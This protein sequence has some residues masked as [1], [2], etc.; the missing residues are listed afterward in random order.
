MKLTS[1]PMRVRTMLFLMAVIGAAAV[2][3]GSQRA[4]AQAINLDKALQ[5]KVVQDRAL[6]YYHFALSKWYENEGDLSRALSEMQEAVRFNESEPGIY[7]GLANILVQ[8]RRVTD[9]IE[10]AQKAAKLD[11]KDPEPHWTL[12]TVYLRMAEGAQARQAGDSIRQA[13]RELELMKEAA[14]DDERAYF[15]IG[16]CYMNLDQPE[17][18]IAALERWQALVPDSDQGYLTIA[19]YFDQAGKQDKAIEYLRKAVEAQPDSVQAI[20]LLAQMYSKAKREKDAIPLYQKIVE[21]T[22][23]TPELKMKLAS[24]LLDEGQSDKALAMLRQ[25][26]QSDPQDPSI[27][28]LLSRALVAERQ[29]ADAIENLKSIVADDPGDIEAQFCLGNAYEQSGE[30]AEAVK[31]F[32]RLIE[33]S[34]SG[35]EELKKNLPL[36]QQHL[37]LSYQDMGDYQKAIAIYEEMAKADPSPR[38]YFALINAYRIDRQFD[39]ALSL[40]KQQYE[41]NPKEENLALVYA[42]A[43]ADAGKV[44]DGAE[45]LEKLLPGSPTN[46][47]VYINLSQIYVQAKRFNDAEKVLRRAEERQL[48]KDRVRFQLAAVYDKQKDHDKAESIFK[49][50]LKEN[51]NDGPTLNYLG[52]MLAERGVRL[53]EA[54]K[55]VKQALVQEPNN[56]AYLDSLGWAYFKMNDLQKAE[57]Y[58]LKAGEIEKRDPVILD[59]IGDL[60]GKTGNL[61]K[62]QEFYKK[63]LG[64]GGEPEE[65]QKIKSKLEKVQEALRKQKRSE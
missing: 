9:A 46:L 40:G 31:I 20:A 12:A 52:Y 25:M 29:F 26:S 21:L 23:G 55:Y 44:K 62:A 38:S 24:A 53:E 34:R 6:S 61:E 19:Q 50:I 14:P 45:V 37:A 17:K 15:A 49:E 10:A 43:L 36:F 18:A 54:V 8:L 58:L 2:F 22:G 39:K 32:S 47:D 59:H 42:R 27:R 5:E 63:S 64:N 7:V 51:P 3:A 4:A 16:Q 48:D 65:V 11:P 56:P 60:Y 33:Q 1:E 28:L 41:K 30:G 35:S 13:V 57:K